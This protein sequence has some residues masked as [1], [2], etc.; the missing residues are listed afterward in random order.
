MSI[1]IE[2]LDFNALAELRQRVDGRMKAMRD[3]S[4]PELRARFAEEAAALGLSLDDVLGRPRKRRSR[5]P[6]DPL[7][8]PGN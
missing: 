1:D 6:A 5:P 7:N 8:G 4:V 3:S 2:H